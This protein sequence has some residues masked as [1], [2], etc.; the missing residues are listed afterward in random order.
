MNK[1]FF[2]IT[3]K[4]NLLDILKILEISKNDLVI[5]K[6]SFVL[7]PEKIY[8]EEF[9]S[10]QNLKKNKL[11]FFT[12]VKTNFKN[13]SSGVCIVEKENFKFLNKDIIKIPYSNPKKGFSK[14]LEK[15][16]NQNQKCNKENT[17]HPSA[18][19]HK[20][21]KIGRN[22]FIGA[23]SIICEG[24]IIDDNSHISERVTISSNC[25]IGKE[26]FIGAGVFIEC[27]IINKKVNIAHNTV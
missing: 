20:T 9:V 26:C 18:I 14:I 3:D 2:K 27:T 1:D 17:I 19:V 24:V 23:Y 5:E 4:I 8:I 7:F 11:S 13:V 10:F 6:D 21:S 22:V 12:N 25:K 15:Y 16:V